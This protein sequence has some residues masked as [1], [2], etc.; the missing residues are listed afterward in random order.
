[1]E[2]IVSIKDLAQFTM[3]MMAAKS[4]QDRDIALQ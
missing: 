3:S 1:M 4:H 2:S